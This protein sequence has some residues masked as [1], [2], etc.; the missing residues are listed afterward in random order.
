MPKLS[1]ALKTITKRKRVKGKPLVELIATVQ[2]DGSLPACVQTNGAPS[3]SSSNPSS[4]SLGRSASVGDVM[5][6]PGARRGARPPALVDAIATSHEE[7][8]ANLAQAYGSVNRPGSS[9]S[10]TTSVSPALSNLGNGNSGIGEDPA[11][12]GWGHNNAAY[13]GS[14]SSTKGQH[15]QARQQQHTP[16]GTRVLSQGPPLSAPA[17]HGLES[18]SFLQEPMPLEQS[19]FDS[20]VS[21][22]DTLVAGTS[23]GGG[24]R[25]SPGASFPGGFSPAAK[26]CLSP[27][28]AEQYIARHNRMMRAGGLQQIGGKVDAMTGMFVMPEGAKSA[29][30][31]GASRRPSAP[32]VSHWGQTQMQ[33]IHSSHP[34]RQRPQKSLSTTSSLASTDVESL[35]T[36]HLL[37]FDDDDD[38]EPSCGSQ[39]H[40]ETG[41]GDGVV[42]VDS[43]VG[44]AQKSATA[45]GNKAG[46]GGGTSDPVGVSPEDLQELEDALLMESFGV[47]D[48][49]LEGEDVPGPFPDLNGNNTFPDLQ[50]VGASLPPLPRGTNGQRGTPRS[51]ASGGVGSPQLFGQQQMFGGASPIHA[52]TASPV[53]CAG[54]GNSSL[55]QGSGNGAPRPGPRGLG[56]PR[57]QVPP[58]AYT[59]SK[60]SRGGNVPWLSQGLGGGISPRVG[61]SPRPPTTPQGSTAVGGRM[62]GS[63]VYVQPGGRVGTGPSP[64]ARRRGEEA[65]PEFGLPSPNGDGTGGTGR[66]APSPKAR[67]VGGKAFPERFPKSPSAALSPRVGLPPL[68]GG[69][70]ER[71]YFPAPAA[72][73]AM[74]STSPLNGSN[75]SH[76]R[77]SSKTW[78]SAPLHGSG[79]DGG[80]LSQVLGGEKSNKPLQ[81]QLPPQLSEIPRRASTG[82]SDV[83]DSDLTKVGGVLSSLSSAESGVRW[84]GRVNSNSS[85][86]KELS[87]NVTSMDEQVAEAAAM[88]RATKGQQLRRRHSAPLPPLAQSQFPELGAQHQQQQQLLS[89]VKDDLFGGIAAD[90][91]GDAGWAPE[92]AAGG[93]VSV[94]APAAE[95]EGD[96]SWWTPLAKAGSAG[97]MNLMQGI[98]SNFE[99]AVV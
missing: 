64:K 52:A 60:S 67:R 65:F 59:P 25:I 48:E 56:R 49:L 72:S 16:G 76:H 30:A 6:R 14:G 95:E 83:S 78:I 85:G 1:A 58:R 90:S 97:E 29:P 43:S 5:A 88:A 45:T 92:Q 69:G 23:P 15:W 3:S 87:N 35:D 37:E 94:P 38:D 84:N 46:S 70:N 50:N 81:Q 91:S 18:G 10:G 47:M 73:A 4:Q 41:A 9:A 55:V 96:D 33:S 74:R 57:N 80:V 54:S 24:D 34:R 89:G 66:G 32:R 39:Q 19:L 75:R 93:G 61:S 51:L 77:T 31:A 13:A 36:S 71:T 28:T 8:T 44:S 20:P 21:S 42:G 68:D 40:L 11:R 86:G 22:C 26:H 12:V 27:T 53:N 63:G 17:R 98:I 99:E 2:R 79:G 62:G 7:Y 82:M